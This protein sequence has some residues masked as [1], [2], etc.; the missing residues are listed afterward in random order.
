MRLLYLNASFL[1]YK[2]YSNAI[3]KF[4]LLVIGSV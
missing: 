3:V 4:F 1:T 2:K